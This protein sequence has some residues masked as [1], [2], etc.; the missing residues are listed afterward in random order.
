MSVGAYCRTLRVFISYPQHPPS[1]FCPCSLCPNFAQY[2]STLYTVFG[3]CS[4]CIY[5]NKK[6]PLFEGP[7]LLRDG[8]LLCS[9]NHDTVA[10]LPH[11]EKGTPVRLY[12]LITVLVP[13]CAAA[14]SYLLQWFLSV[15]FHTIIVCCPAA[16]SSNCVMVAA[17]LQSCEL[18]TLRCS[19][20]WDAA[21][22]RWAAGCRRFER[23]WCRQSQGSTCR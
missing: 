21:V 12:C 17:V 5:I 10:D 4:V 3:V 19:V 20:V 7:Q 8:Q 13:L 14:C 9:I 2:S 23:L 15:M 22:R 11:K 16:D 6:L 1:S 18:V